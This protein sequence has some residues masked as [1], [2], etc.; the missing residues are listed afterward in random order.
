M[1]IFNLFNSKKFTLNDLQFNI[2]RSDLIS[3]SRILFID[4]EE[5]ELIEE[6]KKAGFSIDHIPD[7]TTENCH[8]IE[9]K[10]YHL[11]LL[12]FGNVGKK[13]GKEEGLTLLRLI[14]RINPT[15]VVFSYT[16]KALSASQ[17]EF[18]TMSDGNLPK[19]AAITDSM[20]KIEEG[21]RKAHSIE[22]NWI[23]LL[24]LLG[25]TVGSEKD[26]ELQNDFIRALKKKDKIELFKKRFISDKF[27]D[28]NKV[29][30]E[31]LNKLIEIG[32][33]ALI[34]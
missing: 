18:F 1:G 4:D 15:I 25:I 13:L 16:S 22:R 11:I 32:I 17:A 34:A 20:E 28:S 31:I 33:K 27:G 23:S 14:K 26:L 7:L 6:L 19:D 8:L 12:D 10:K 29:I 5:P 30:I 24:H 2:I 9:Q 21:L 3:Q